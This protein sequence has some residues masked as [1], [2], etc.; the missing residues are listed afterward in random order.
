VNYAATRM[1]IEIA[2]GNGVERFVFASSCSVYGASDHLADEHSAVNRFRCTPRPRWIRKKY[3]SRRAR[4]FPPSGP[5]AGD[6]VR[7]GYRPRFDLVV[8]LLVARRTTTGSSPSTTADSGVRLF[9]SATSRM[10]S[11]LTLKLPSVWSAARSSTWAIPLESHSGRGPR[12]DPQG[13]PRA[14]IL[15]LDNPD[16]RN[17]RVSFRRIH[18]RLG[19]RCILGLDEGILEL[20]R[21]FER[22]QSPTTRMCVTIIKSFWHW[23]AAASKTNRVQSPCHGRVFPETDW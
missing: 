1:M 8:N 3:Y 5:A 20:R 9:M 17:Y 11:C 15:N 7:S 10:A 13:H 19:F 21:S 12:E 22:M 6:G 4:Q 2:K 18:D 23:P 14:R 16:R